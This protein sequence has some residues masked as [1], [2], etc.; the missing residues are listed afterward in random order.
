MRIELHCHST[1]S[2][3][4]LP[5][6]EVAARAKENGVTLFCL[7]DHDSSDGY[8]A[9]RQVFPDAIRGVELSCVEEEKTVHLLVYGLPNSDWTAIE[10][11]LTSQREVRRTRVHTIAERLAKHGAIFDPDALL[12]RCHGTVGRPHVAQELIR[13][14]AVSSREEAFSRYLKDGGPG[15]VKV[16]RLSVADGLDLAVAAGARVSLAHPH[17]HGDRAEALVVRYR[18]A[19]LTG[20]EVHYA[21]YNA[22]KRKIWAALAKRH[23]LVATG[24]SDFHGK[25]ITSVRTLGVEI[26]HEAAHNLLNWLELPSLFPTEL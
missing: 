18:D 10:T 16:S 15:D 25:G 14:G 11:V 7:T 4:N 23:G 19:G 26:E 13:V 3:G 20:L 1:H 2:D 9:T 17:M 21:I 24:G 12:A 8:E 22:K 5:A 6:T